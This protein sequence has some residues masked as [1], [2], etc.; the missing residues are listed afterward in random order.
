MT[1][2]LLL[3]ND[4]RGAPGV[5]AVGTVL[6]LVP[7]GRGLEAAL[8]AGRGTATGVVT[9]HAVVRVRC[10]APGLA[11]HAF[12]NFI[13]SQDTVGGP[14]QVV[15]VAVAIATAATGGAA[16]GW[17]GPRRDRTTP[18]GPPDPVRCR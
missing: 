15:A 5:E 13:A 6:R 10:L 7:P 2:L 1:S 9:G 16:A 14:S 3:L 4:G 17:F 18:P 11:A 12:N 8:V